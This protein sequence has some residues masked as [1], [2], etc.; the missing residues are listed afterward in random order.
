MRNK[1][2]GLGALIMLLPTVALG[3]HQTTTHLLWPNDD[4]VTYGKTNYTDYTA[5]DMAKTHSDNVWS[6]LGKVDIHP[7]VQGETGG[8]TLEFLDYTSTTDGLC[9][10]EY[11]Q[12]VARLRLNTAYMDPADD[13]N[14]KSCAAHEMGHAMGLGDHG[15]EYQ[16][17]ALMYGHVGRFTAPMQHD[18]DDFYTRW[19]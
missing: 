2:L 6:A 1:L 8:I 13:W 4:A 10:Y 19:P 12:P 15:G 5:Y 11:N 3:S 7:Y 18:K 9:G 17:N 14:E 16:S